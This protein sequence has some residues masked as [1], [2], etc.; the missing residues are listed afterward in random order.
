[1]PGFLAKI[2]STIKKT[3][4]QFGWNELRRNEGVNSFQV[5]VDVKKEKKLS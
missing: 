4:E 3:E 1:M 5:G 2:F